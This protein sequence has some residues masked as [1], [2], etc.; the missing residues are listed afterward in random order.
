MT[1]TEIPSSIILVGL[2]LLVGSVCLQ[3]YISYNTYV[4]MLAEV[5]DVKSFFHKLIDGIEYGKIVVNPFSLKYGVLE[6]YVDGFQILNFDNETLLS[7]FSISLRYIFHNSLY[8]YG[9]VIIEEGNRTYFFYSIIANGGTLILSVRPRIIFSGN[10]VLVGAVL[11]NINGSLKISCGKYSFTPYVNI[12]KRSY[13]PTTT[14]ILHMQIYSPAYSFSWSFNSS[15]VNPLIF[16]CI[17]I[18]VDVVGG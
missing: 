6:F 9:N 1:S 11:F 8:P 13:N 14:R 16:N 18:S 7:S 17:I 2:I 10:S 12:V 3:F 5:N 15:G 4:L